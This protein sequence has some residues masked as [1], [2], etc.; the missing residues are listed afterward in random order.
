[1]TIRVDLN[2]ET[3]ARL[4]SEA[5]SQG[6]PER[7]AEAPSQRGFDCEFSTSRCTDRR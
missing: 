3:E 6:V 4:I 7:L 1:M 2:P 5:R